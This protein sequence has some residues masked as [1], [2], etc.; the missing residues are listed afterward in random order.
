MLREGRGNAL[1]S[2]LDAPEPTQDIDGEYGDARSGGNS[3]K[4]FLCA[5]FAVREAVAA[6]HDG[7]Q[8]GNLGNGAG[9]QGLDGRKTGVER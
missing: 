8:T 1:G 3:G 2:A 9:E 4:R 5:W 7:N 6:D